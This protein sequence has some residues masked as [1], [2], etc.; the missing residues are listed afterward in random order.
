MVLI[1]YICTNESNKCPCCDMQLSWKSEFCSESSSCMQAA[2]A[3]VSYCA[4]SPKSSLGVDVIS[5]ESS[6]TGPFIL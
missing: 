1:A 4:D 5:T 3:L 2:K 6:Y